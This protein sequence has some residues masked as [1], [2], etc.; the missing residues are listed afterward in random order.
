MP[1]N[2]W[3]C[4]MGTMGLPHGMAAFLFVKHVD[5]ANSAPNMM[6]SPC[7][8]LLPRGVLCP[9]SPVRSNDVPP[10]PRGIRGAG[11]APACSTTQW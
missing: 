10:P 3:R 7:L 6:I 4:Q 1:A 8:P 9:V 2:R 11:P 5:P